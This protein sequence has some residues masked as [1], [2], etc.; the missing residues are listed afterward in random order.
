MGHV[1]NSTEPEITN[2]T[3]EAELISCCYIQDM[4]IW[5]CFNTSR[6]FLGG[7]AMEPPPQK[8]KKTCRM[9]VMDGERCS[10]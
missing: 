8:K 7:N 3:E 1:P 2:M 9:L 10:V 6:I 4:E 5:N